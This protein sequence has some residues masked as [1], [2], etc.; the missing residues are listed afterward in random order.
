MKVITA[1]VNNPIFIQIQ[2]HT[3]KK[4]MKCDYEFI[5]FNDAKNFPDTTNGNDITIKNTI[6]QLCEKLGIKCINIPNEHHK[7]KKEISCRTAD[8]M[9]FILNYQINNP[10]KYLILDSDMFLIDYF[11]ESDYEKYDCAIVLQTREN[12]KIYYFWNGVF[13]FDINKIKNINLMNW[14]LYPGCDTGGMMFN[15]MKK[16]NKVNSN[17]DN[18]V[19]NNDDIYLMKYL[20]SLTWNESDIPEN[21]KSNNK[22]V[23]FIKNDPR[24]QN[25]NFFCEIYDNKFFHYRAGSNWEKR[26]MKLHVNLSVQL[27]KI[28]IE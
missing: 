1:V 4:Y 24:N 13:Y 22:L 27:R 19:F 7:F 3:L 26:G 17:S 9:N 20:K 11:Y 21:I 28:L 18:E 23:E 10:D 12:N 6:H 15:W 8:S 2:F 5:V 16:Q 14:N 25:D